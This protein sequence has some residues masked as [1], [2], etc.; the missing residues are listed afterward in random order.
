MSSLGYGPLGASAAGA[1][2]TLPM[3]DGQRSA[4]ADFAYKAKALFIEQGLDIVMDEARF[5]AAI[6]A[7]EQRDAV[8]AQ[9]KTREAIEALAA[10]IGPSSS[11]VK[12]R[13][14]HPRASPLAAC[15][16]SNAQI[17]V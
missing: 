17:A 15:G 12:A 16:R 7:A 10:I 1:A 2:S 8:R 3:F 6:K 13:G 14:T 9:A 11:E 5:T 4:W